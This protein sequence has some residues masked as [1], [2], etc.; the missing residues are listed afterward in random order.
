MKFVQTCEGAYEMLGHLLED[1]HGLPKSKE[2]L[3]KKEKKKDA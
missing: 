2:D 3:G 1:V